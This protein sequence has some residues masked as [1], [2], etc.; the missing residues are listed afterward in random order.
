LL[1]AARDYAD[2]VREV[3]FVVLAGREKET[4]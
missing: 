3:K 1:D 2:G 4:A